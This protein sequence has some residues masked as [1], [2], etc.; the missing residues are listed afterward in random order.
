MRFPIHAPSNGSCWSGRV[1]T[2]PG[3]PEALVMSAQNLLRAGRTSEAAALL[4]HAAQSPQAP[5]PVFALL[6]AAL[7]V[8]GRFPEARA[9]VGEGLLRRPGYAPLLLEDAMLCDS[10]GDTGA[11][12]LAYTRAVQAAPE[13]VPAHINFGALL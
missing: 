10:A 7:R 4:Q 8:Q 3:S 2:D 11:A 13:S 5:A 1:V 9:A 12:V 6:A